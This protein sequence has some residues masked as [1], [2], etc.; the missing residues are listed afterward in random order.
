MNICIVTVM[1]GDFAECMVGFARLPLALGDPVAVQSMQQ[2]G[3]VVA[4]WDVCWMQVGLC[5]SC[6]RWI[7]C[8]EA[9]AAWL[10]KPSS[11]VLVDSNS[12][13][14][15][16]PVYYVISVHHSLAV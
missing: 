8:E 14:C 15:S 1:N 13:L 7:N 9:W 16:L 5:S 10:C 2:V 11:C 6:C 3:F 12:A 4:C